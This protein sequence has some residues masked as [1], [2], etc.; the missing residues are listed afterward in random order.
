VLLAS[1]CW[2]TA[3]KHRYGLATQPHTVCD[4]F[5]ISSK[6]VHVLLQHDRSSS[7]GIN[8]PSGDAAALVSHKQI[9][10]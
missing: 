3:A 1:C 9:V 8:S 7:T 2:Q 4:L 6:S 5:C 10:G